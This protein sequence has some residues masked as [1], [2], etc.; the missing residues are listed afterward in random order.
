MIGFLQLIR[1]LMPILLPA[2]S[3]LPLRHCKG[4]SSLPDRLVL[5]NLFD[6]LLSLLFTVFQD[7]RHCY[8]P[9]YRWQNRTCKKSL[10]ESLF[11]GRQC[12]FKFCLFQTENDVVF[13]ATPAMVKGM[14][15]K[16]VVSLPYVSDDPNPDAVLFA[17]FK[18][19]IY[20][21]LFY[22]FKSRHLAGS[23]R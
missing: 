23:F 14:P 3:A 16:H 13:T 19:P 9:L 5:V 7:S 12:R 4:K 17:K 15:N 10:D 21:R 2:G 8:H 22:P 6:F 20:G 1:N 18:M 11:D